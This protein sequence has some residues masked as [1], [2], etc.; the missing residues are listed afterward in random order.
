MTDWLLVRNEYENTVDSLRAIA[1]RHG[2][3]HTQIRKKVDLEDWVNDDRVSKVPNIS[4]AHTK[5]LGRVALRKIEEIKTELG[6]KYSPV[7]EPLIVMYAKNYERYLDL[8][9]DLLKDGVIAYSVKTGAQYM[10]PTFTASLAVQKN[11]VTIAN[12]LG[13]SIASRKK[14]NISFSKDE[15]SQTIFDFTKEINNDGFALNDI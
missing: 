1:K 3:N 7:D 11:L 14:L 9:Q 10:S 2:T 4:N 8:E 6:E 13:L 12:Q 5:I 15:D